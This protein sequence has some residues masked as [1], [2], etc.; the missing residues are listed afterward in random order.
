FEHVA[1]PGAVGG[2]R[3]VDRPVVL[4][5][6]TERLGIRDDVLLRIDRPCEPA[7]ASPADGR[8]LA[9]V[10]RRL[11]IIALVGRLR[12][13]LLAL[14]IIHKVLFA[15]TAIV[16][17]GAVVGTWLTMAISRL[18][19]DAE[20]WELFVAFATIGV[21]ASVV[22]NYLVLRAAFAPLTALV[23]TVSEVQ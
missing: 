6:A 5:P 12:D 21:I 11:A 18:E 20:H 13:R 3:Q 8:R 22:V 1:R 19:P 7:S 4:R 23:Q 9:S 2:Q 15:N 17:L 14:P 10:V 16:V